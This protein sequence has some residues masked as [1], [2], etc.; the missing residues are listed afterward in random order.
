[1]TISGRVVTV[2]FDL[3]TWSVQPCPKLHLSCTYVINLEK[4]QRAVP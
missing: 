3:R 4:F 2:T 1:M